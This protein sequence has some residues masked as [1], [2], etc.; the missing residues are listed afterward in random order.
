MTINDL[1]AN[2]LS[3]NDVHFD[4]LHGVCRVAT[5]YKGYTKGTPRVH[6]GYTKGTLKRMD[7]VIRCVTK[8]YEVHICV[9]TVCVK[10]VNPFSL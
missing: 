4:I 1:Q 9:K 7:I 6:Q 8:V 5:F 2:N 3:R 10:G